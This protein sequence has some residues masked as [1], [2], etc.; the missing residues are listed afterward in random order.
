MVSTG[1]GRESEVDRAGKVT[2]KGS[3]ESEVD[4]AGKVTDKRRVQKGEWRE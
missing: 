3:G 4:R 2:D 1:R